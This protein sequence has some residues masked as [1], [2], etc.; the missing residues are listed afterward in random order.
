M[1][2]NDPVDPDHSLHE[3]GQY[4]TPAHD[5]VVTGQIANVHQSMV[6]PNPPDVNFALTAKPVGFAAGDKDSVNSIFDSKATKKRVHDEMEI[7]RRMK[8]MEMQNKFDLLKGPETKLAHDNLRAKM[9]EARAHV[10]AFASV[11]VPSK[12]ASLIKRVLLLNIFVCLI[13]LSNLL[14]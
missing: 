13:C 10:P 5:D 1:S 4:F 2:S 12:L 8:A 7:D 9:E 3:D 14:V 6:N 11:N